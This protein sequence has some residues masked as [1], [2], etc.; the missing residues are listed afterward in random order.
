VGEDF[1]CSTS[2]GLAGEKPGEQLGRL[3]HGHDSTVQ[4]E[5]DDPAGE[6]LQDAVR[7]ALEVRELLEMTPEIGVGRLESRALLEELAAM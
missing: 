5:G 6:G 7:V 2:R 4:I 1:P 3:I